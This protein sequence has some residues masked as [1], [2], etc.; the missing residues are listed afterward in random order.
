[1]NERINHNTF[2]ELYYDYGWY[3]EIELNLFGKLQ[4]MQLIIEGDEDAK[5]E[6]VQIEAYKN[7]IQNKDE[8]LRKCEEDTYRYYQKINSDYSAQFGDDFKDKL[9]PIIKTQKELNNLIEPKELLFTR[10]FG[11]SIRE[12]GILCECSW[13][14]EHGLAIKYQNEEI[15]EIGYQDI[16]I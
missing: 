8:L 6:A 14:I 11:R 15:I 4:K 12:F 9:A 5:F 13:E 2:G 7:F 16:I 3:K 1:M 10:V